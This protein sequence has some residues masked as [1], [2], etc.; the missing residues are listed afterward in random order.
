M[1]ALS[2]TDTP[3]STTGWHRWLRRPLSAALILLL[4]YVGLSFLN[5]PH[6]SLG[7]D[8]GGKVATLV[9]MSRNG[10][11]DPDVGYWAAQ[12]DPEA[13]VHGL[14]YTS[15]IGDRY[16]NVT[17]LPMVLAAGP[18]YD[19]GGY[20]LALLLPM[21]GA[22]AAAFA[23][24]AIARRVGRTGGWA[25][26]WVIGLASPLAIYALDFWE[27]TIGVALM[28]WGAV[29]LYDAVHDRPTW[30]RGLAAGAAFGA[31]FS[32]RTEALAYGFA[33]VAVTCLVLL[34]GRK[35]LAGAVLTGASAMV[36]LAALF[37]A[38]A[39]LEIAVLG[40]TFR[41]GRASG[42]AGAGGSSLGLRVKE[43]IVTGLSPVPSVDPAAFVLGIGLALALGYLV[44]CSW[45]RRERTVSVIVA[46]LVA[47]VYLF[48]FSTG[49]GF[50]PG[51]VATTPLAVA[52]VV[53]GWSRPRAKLFLAFA[54]VPLPLVFFFQF[55]GGAAPQWAGRYILTTG[56]ILAAVGVAC[57]PRLEQ[58]VRRFLLG[59]SVAV[60]VFGLAWLS[61]RSH[62]VAQAADVL[63]ARPET[64]LIQPQGFIA[65]EF[66]ATY[67]RKPWLSTGGPDDLPF[68]AQVAAESGADSF[69]LVDTVTDREPLEFDGW[70]RGRSELV[71]LDFSDFQ[72]TT[73]TRT[74]G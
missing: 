66:G 61:V 47:F 17:S 69:A 73:Y 16:L 23:A 31:A 19:A 7:T 2:L 15:K 72:V 60:T 12:A 62:Q 59:L 65:R 30:W 57:L 50:V 48:R 41:S 46:A 45:K 38:N 21:A 42:A 32:M 13:K 56:T 4:I 43:A 44:W 52:G 18:L 27:H 39:T 49:L 26:F 35:N 53:L 33:M 71:H 36:G 55:P 5:D 70:T 8:T 14:Y 9:A 74:S 20:R 37:L 34:V 67:G 6:G 22:I 11:L 10:D 51:L 25:A 68:A 58:W 1:P 24:R 63:E 40:S 3:A 54:L 28:A 64:V 29:A